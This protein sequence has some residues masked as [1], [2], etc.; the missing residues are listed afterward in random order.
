[1]GRTMGWAGLVCTARL[2]VLIKPSNILVKVGRAVYPLLGAPA[3]PDRPREWVE[4]DVQ[5]E[6]FWLV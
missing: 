2:S 4:R 5:G 1:M 3:H 6:K